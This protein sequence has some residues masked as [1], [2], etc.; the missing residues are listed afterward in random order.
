MRVLQNL[1]DSVRLLE[2][3][4]F[5]RCQAGE[6]SL[7]MH[8]SAGKCGG[9][10][11]WTGLFERAVD[12]M[13]LERPGIA[14]CQSVGNYAESRMH[15]HGRIRPEQERVLHWL[16]SSRDRTPNELEIWY[17]GEDRF[18]LTLVAPNGARFKAPLGENVKLVQDGARWGTLYHR[19]CEP[20]SRMN[21]VDIYLRTGSSPGHYRIEL[22]GLDVVDGRF[23]AWI[24]RDAGGHHQSRFPRSQATPQ[25]TTNTI[26]NSYRG[27][28]VGAYDGTALDRPPTPFS[29]C[30]PTAD[31]RQKPE[32]AAPGK[33]ILAARSLPAGGWKGERRLTVMSGT[34]MAAP[35]VSGTVALMMQAAGRPLTI[36]EVRLMLIGT[37]D[38]IAG[39]PGRSSTRLGYGYL[40]TIAA[41]EAARKLATQESADEGVASGDDERGDSAAEWALPWVV[42]PQP[43]AHHAEDALAADGEDASS[44]AADF[45]DWAAAD[46]DDDVWG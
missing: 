23:H 40:N 35:C 45:D 26:C 38:P 1:S 39:R 14:L 30:G 25:Y 11:D 9:P 17:S 16:I 6:R 7:V 24:E 28:A 31:G 43:F 4:D 22:R 41:V 34:S 13:V 2:G 5:I 37:T 21:H 19:W 8:L 20:N 33:G 42:D 3:L 32:L 12:A 10:H 36:S 29:S 44:T 46:S 18:D 27:I 15:V